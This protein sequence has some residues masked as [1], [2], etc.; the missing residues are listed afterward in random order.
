VFWNLSFAWYSRLSSP[1]I[2]C[3]CQS[4]FTCF[5]HNISNLWTT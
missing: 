5:L 1:K 4:F 3:Y 2:N